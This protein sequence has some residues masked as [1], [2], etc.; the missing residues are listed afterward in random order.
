MAP[1]FHLMAVGAMLGRMVGEAPTEDDQKRFRAPSFDGVKT[2]S[3]IYIELV[4][5]T[6]YLAPLRPLTIF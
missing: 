1:R 3:D 5:C 4:S 6:R 2:E